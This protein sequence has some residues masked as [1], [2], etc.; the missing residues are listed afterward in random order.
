MI[1]LKKIFSYA[2]FELNKKQKNP[3]FFES[4][5][6]LSI[7]HYKNC[8]EYKKIC[9]NLFKKIETC[10]S[11]EELPF[12][13][14][15]IFKNINLKSTTIDKLSKTLHS[16]GTSGNSKSKINVDR[17]T[18]LLQSRALLNI[19]S[20]V[21]KKKCTFFF[22]TDNMGK[23]LETIS[24]STA[25]VRGF[26]QMSKKNY[27][28]FKNNKLNYSKLINF[29][30]KNPKEEFVIFGFTSNIWMDLLENLNKKKLKIPKNRG[31]LIHGGG[32]KKLENISVSKKE[33]NK[34]SKNILGIRNVYNYYGMVEQTGSIFLECEENYFH[35]SLYSDILI[36]DENLSI[37]KKKEV[38]LLQ[39][40]SLIQSSYPGHNILTEDLGRIEGVDNCKCGRKG[41][42]F[43]FI[44]RVPGTEK[45]GCSDA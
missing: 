7:H 33:F 10:N 19:F 29:V 13:H 4:Q 28:I 30:K 40:L 11:L 24:A 2:A 41:K 26:S 38:G 14:V 45:R 9:K 23:D 16:S 20:S 17:Y 6:K 1:N 31:I 32:W 21:I 25:A 22:I 12:V 39:T 3:L 36:R 44:G 18:S 8:P 43:S 35:C 42:Y 15:N 27:S 37:A 5:K 34:K